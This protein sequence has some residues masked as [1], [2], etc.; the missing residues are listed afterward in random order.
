MNASYLHFFPFYHSIFQLLV[1][2]NRLT[3]SRK[4]VGFSRASSRILERGEEDKGVVG[5]SC[6]KSLGDLRKQEVCE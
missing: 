1:T 2:E 4:I 5:Y 6:S 3:V